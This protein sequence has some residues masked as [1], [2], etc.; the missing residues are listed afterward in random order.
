VAHSLKIALLILSV[1]NLWSAMRDV[2]IGRHLPNA[3]ATE[4]AR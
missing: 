4:M 1:S 3:V 2:L